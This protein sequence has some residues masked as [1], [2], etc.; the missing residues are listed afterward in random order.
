MSLHSHRLEED[1][2]MIALTYFYIPLK[3]MKAV[4]FHPPT[5]NV[6]PPV[7]EYPFKDFKAL[8]KTV[9]PFAKINLMLFLWIDHGFFVVHIYLHINTC[10]AKESVL[11]KNLNVRWIIGKTIILYW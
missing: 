7:S 9:K 3:H 10:T 4:M 6:I 8:D 11:A 2:A 1:G 5:Q